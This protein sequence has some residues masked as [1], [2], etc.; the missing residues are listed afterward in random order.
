MKNSE[1]KKQATKRGC[2]PQP[3]V[4][5]S[6]EY[7]SSTDPGGSSSEHLSS[8]SPKSSET[9]TVDTSASSPSLSSP[10]VDPIVSDV[11]SPGNVASSNISS[12][13]PS[14]LLMLKNETTLPSPWIDHSP[15]NML[16]CRLSTSN[17]RNCAYQN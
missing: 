16:I 11:D 12:P 2:D 13:L 9:S 8:E 1:R 7:S 14:P 4:D 15:E 17:F 3:P 5:A 6:S 10:A